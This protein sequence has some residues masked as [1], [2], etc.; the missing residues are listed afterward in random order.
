MTK[1]HLVL[2]HGMGTHDEATFKKTVTG[3]LN[4]ASGYF[5]SIGKF[6]DEVTLHYI[7]YN[8]I[9]ED[10]RRKIAETAIGDLDTKFPNAPSFIADLSKFHGKFDDDSFFYTHWL[11]VLIYR[12]FYKDAVQVRIAKQLLEAMRLAIDEAADI[13]ILCHS[14]GSAPMHDTLHKLYINDI[15]PSVGE[16]LLSA[17]LNRIKSITMVANVSLLL[18]A[19]ANPY[20]SAVKPGLN[21]GICDYFLN[22]RHVLDPIASID[23]FD[24][25]SHWVDIRPLQFKNISINGIERANVHDLDHYLA[26]PR[27]FIPLFYHLFQGTFITKQAEVE[28]AYAEHDETTVQG[29]FEKLRH[30]LGDASF[31]LQWN[32]DTM[33]FDYTGNLKDIEKQLVGFID[34]LETIKDDFSAIKK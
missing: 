31:T 2:V 14:L 24:P 6:E 32:P 11:D 9:F 15:D 8:S 5:S 16:N 1:P 7:D 13:H 28:K 3:P 22:C 34:H 26:N 27:I 33:E 25:D 4:K 21:G 12:S 19:G 29:R 17:G 30:E 18:E 23:K 20:T 10:V